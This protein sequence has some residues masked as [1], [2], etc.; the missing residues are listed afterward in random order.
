MGEILGDRSHDELACD[1]KAGTVVRLPW[2][3]RER[4]INS[5][6]NR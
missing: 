5:S 2:I 3:A 6:S 4:L 1:R